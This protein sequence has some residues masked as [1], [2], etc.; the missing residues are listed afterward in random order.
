[1]QRSLSLLAVFAHPDDEGSVSGALARYAAEGVRIMLACAT[2]GEAATIYCN[3]CATPETLAQVRTREMESACKHLGVGDLR[4]LDWPDGGINQAKRDDAIARIVELMHETHP[5]VVITHPPHG[6][7]AH[8]D[9]LALWQ[10]VSEAWRSIA[11][12]KWAPSKL[13]YRA[14]PESVFDLVPQLREFRIQLKGAQLPFTPTPNEEVT[15]ALDV[16]PWLA[17]KEAAWNAHSSQLNPNGFMSTLSEEI[18]RTW[19][20]WEYFVLAENRL[21]VISSGQSN[22]QET[23][24]FAGL[25]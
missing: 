17:Q 9:H 5:Q 19:R 15:T 21:S 25:H 6:G 11:Q 8:P 24:L 22:H 20:S 14:I 10:I 7:Y 3:D 12:H 23:D 4:W 1:M 16:N 18:R 13:Y 2:R